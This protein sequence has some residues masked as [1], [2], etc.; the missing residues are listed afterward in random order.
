ML[1]PVT[2]WWAGL[3][4]D[5]QMRFAVSS[6]AAALV[7]GLVVGFLLRLAIDRRT[8][9]NKDRYEAFVAVD[10]AGTAYWDMF[11]QQGHWT[12]DD[13]EFD[14]RHAALRSADARARL[15]C[16]RKSTMKALSELN[17]A[18]NQIPIVL[19]QHGD[20]GAADKRAREAFQMTVSRFRAE[21]GLAKA[22]TWAF[23]AP[24]VATA[25]PAV[26]ST[27]AQGTRQFEV[28]PPSFP[29]VVLPEPP[30]WSRERP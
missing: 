13:A 12:V 3:T 8:R 28:T 25:G 1:T 7:L 27:A 14:K 5:D 10:L 9:W 30:E 11:S 20:F 22:K 19:R 2:D 23:P 29:D 17:S 15:T 16:R 26:T 21:L 4:D 6:V 24:G 18:L